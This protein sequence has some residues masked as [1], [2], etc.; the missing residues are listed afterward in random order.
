MTLLTESARAQLLAHGAAR[1]RGEHDDPFPVVKLYTPDFHAVWLLAALD[2]ADGDTAYG[3]C[4]AGL[5][6]P[7]LG[8]VSIRYLES[9]R[10]PNGYPVARDHSFVAARRLSEYLERARTDGSISD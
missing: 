6:S 10:G 1:V 7:E 9:M 4:D 8:T 2:P 5:G 3:L